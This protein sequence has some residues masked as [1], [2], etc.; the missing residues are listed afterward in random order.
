MARPRPYPAPAVGRARAASPRTNGSKARSAK[1]G[2]EPRPRSTAR[3]GAPPAPSR[4]TEL[5]RSTSGWPCARALTRRL[6]SDAARRA[7]RTRAASD[8][9]SCASPLGERRAAERFFGDASARANRRGPGS[10]CARSARPARV[11][12]SRSPRIVSTATSCFSTSSSGRDGARRS[13]GARARR[14]AIARDLEGDPRTAKRRPELVADGAQSSRCPRTIASTRSAIRL[15]LTATSRTSRATQR[16][17][18]RRRRCGTRDRRRRSDRPRGRAARVA[19]R[20]DSRPRPPCA[21]STETTRTARGR[22]ATRPTSARVRPELSISSAPTS[23]PPRTT[24]IAMCCGPSTTMA[25]PRSRERPHTAG[26]GARGSRTRCASKPVTSRTSPT[27]ARG[28][29]GVVPRA[30]R[31][32]PMLSRHGL[33][34]HDGLGTRAR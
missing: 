14:Q 2:S 13:G 16:C 31:R 23:S 30:G 5:Q 12:S 17:A 4:Q 15:K 27:K 33:G 10:P 28:R 7:A 24:G 29:L 19:A 3:D 1:P 20:A 34:A 32:A 9:T 26:R 22:A 25:A 6:W 21:E 18:P 8:A 11:T